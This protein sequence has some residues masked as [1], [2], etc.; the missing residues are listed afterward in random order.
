MI[1]Y[2]EVQRTAQAEIDQVVGGDRL[3]DFSDGESLPY[4]GAVIKETLRWH[5]VT[6]LGSF[7]RC[8]LLYL[9]NPN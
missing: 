1:K 8:D 3:P 5:N 6:P 4:I 7:N 9:S 2:P